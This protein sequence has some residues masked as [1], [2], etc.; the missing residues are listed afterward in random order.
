VPAGLSVSVAPGRKRIRAPLVR[1]EHD[2]H[3]T[4]IFQPMFT[5]TDIRT[6]FPLYETEYV[7]SVSRDHLAGI[8]KVFI[9]DPPFVEEYPSYK[10]KR[11]IPKWTWDDNTLFRL[12]RRQL[13]EAQIQ[14]L[15]YGACERK[16]SFS[17]VKTKKQ[18]DMIVKRMQTAKEVNRLLL[19]RDS[20]D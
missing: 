17:D 9:M 6:S 3:C 7:K 20:H 1:L 10:S 2:Q 12:V 5:R 15:E 4:Q 11:W 18:R 13:L 8:G 19:Q 14:L 16:V